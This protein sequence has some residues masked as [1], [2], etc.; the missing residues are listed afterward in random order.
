[1]KPFEKVVV[2]SS[3][4]QVLSYSVDFLTWDSSKYTYL[5]KNTRT[6]STNLKHANNDN[7]R[8]HTRQ[9]LNSSQVQPSFSQMCV[10]SPE[11]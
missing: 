7:S 6:W 9:F 4:K 2:L 1:M 5:R 11:I 3:H 8:H 10:F